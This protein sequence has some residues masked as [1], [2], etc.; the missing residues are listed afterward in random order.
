[1]KNLNCVWIC[2][3]LLAVCFLPDMAI[4]DDNEAARDH[5]KLEKLTASGTKVTIIEGT[6]VKT[7]DDFV[8]SA[9]ITTNPVRVP[10]DNSPHKARLAVLPAVFS[11]HF[12]P[13]INVSEQIDVSGN[14]AIKAIFSTVH[15]MR[16]EA[17][18]FTVSL[19][20][21]F[22]ASRKFDVLERTRLKEVLKEI[23][24][25]ESDYA[26]VAKAVP[27][28]LALNAEYVALPE[29]EVIHL[30]AEIKDV[31]YVD[32]VRPILKGK[33]I[34]RIRIVDTGTTKMVAAFTEEVQVEKKLKANNPFWVS[35]INNLTIDLYAAAAQKTLQHTLEA[36][37]PVRI[38][39]VKDGVA[40]INRGEGAIR[41]GD[42]FEV[43][44]LGA[45]YVDPDTGENLGQ[46]ENRIG[47]IKV[48][49]VTPKF[50]EAQI[51]EGADSLSGDNED[52]LCRETAKSIERK[53]TLKQTPIA[54]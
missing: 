26:D 39:D 45:S 31:P 49:R 17:P 7:G 23:D 10:V 42:E 24:F 43:Y 36:I 35:E 15:E 53:T 2:I 21:A 50:S 34:A 3:S 40:V 30:V 4:A 47:L 11:R 32:T 6:D 20:E 13:R 52:F 25:G 33:M 22:V 48:I 8:E 41:V 12:E 44:S 14:V 29:I 51:L 27:A 5:I 1:M 37:Y 9:T 46:R 54:W 28:G 38:L 18:S 16:M 19:A